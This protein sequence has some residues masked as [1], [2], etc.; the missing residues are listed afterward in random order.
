MA[1]KVVAAL[2]SGLILIARQLPVVLKTKKWLLER[3]DA[4]IEKI[5][6]DADESALR[7]SSNEYVVSREFSLTEIMQIAGRQSIGALR[8]LKRLEKLGSICRTRSGGWESIK[9]KQ[10]RSRI[11][12]DWRGTI[13]SPFSA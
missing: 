5:F 1:W 6:E 11:S 12:R 10:V 7:V 2:C 3:H 4:P 13:D 8:S 9:N